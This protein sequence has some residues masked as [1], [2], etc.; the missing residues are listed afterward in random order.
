MVNCIGALPDPEAVLAVS[1]T[2]LHDYGKEPRP[3]RKVGHL[4]VT[5][6][7]PDELDALLVRLQGLPG[8]VDTTS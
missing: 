7:D 4:T 5:A 1:N 3:G 2:H 6:T 8:T